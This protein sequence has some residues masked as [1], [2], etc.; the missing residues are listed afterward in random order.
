L[1]F[2]ARQHICESVG[3]LGTEWHGNPAEGYT[4]DGFEAVRLLDGYV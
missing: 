3:I 1:P 2:G 4:C